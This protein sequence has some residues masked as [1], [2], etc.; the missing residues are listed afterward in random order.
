VL[1]PGEP[2]DDSDP[3]PK[4]RHQRAIVLLTDGQQFGNRGDGYK[5]AFGRGEPAGPNGMNNRLRAVAQNIKAQDIKIYAIQFFH[6][7]GPLQDL[8]Q[9]IASGPTSPYYHYAPD[10]DTLRQVFQ[11]IA[12]HL[13]ELRLSK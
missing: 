5:N 9:E 10:G 8:M 2:F 7:S 4:G 11:E 13:S 3:F 12:N 6:N 1:T